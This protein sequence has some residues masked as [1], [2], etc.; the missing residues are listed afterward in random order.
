MTAIPIALA[1][2]PYLSAFCPSVGVMFAVE[3]TSSLTAKV[4]ALIL[5]ARSLAVL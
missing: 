3:M 1:I 2:K 4:P 5:V